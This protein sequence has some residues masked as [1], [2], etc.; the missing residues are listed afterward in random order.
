MAPPAPVVE[1]AA[2]QAVVAN[3]TPPAVVEGGLQLELIQQEAVV[4]TGSPPI[5]NQSENNMDLTVSPSK[6]SA[7]SRTNPAASLS[8]QKRPLNT[9]QQSSSSSE[10]SGSKSPKGIRSDTGFTVQDR[11]RGRA[12]KKRGGEVAADR[13]PISKTPLASPAPPRSPLEGIILKPKMG[14]NSCN[15]A[16]SK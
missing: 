3:Q 10:R 4:L 12:K 2:S 11:S 6:I 8:G 13:Q 9:T 15:G 5:T 7:F 1:G 16:T 14:D